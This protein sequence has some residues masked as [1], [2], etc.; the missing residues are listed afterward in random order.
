M[1]G[2]LGPDLWA[3]LKPV[4]T[5]PSKVWTSNSEGS[6]P[7]EAQSAGFSTPFNIPPTLRSEE[8]NK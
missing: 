3:E 1:A 6:R 5:I 4:R 8:L 2:L 7:R